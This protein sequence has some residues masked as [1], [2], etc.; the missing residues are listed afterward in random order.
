M[1][2]GFGIGASGAK[3]VL[4]HVVVGGGLLGQT[5]CG[6]FPPNAACAATFSVS[7]APFA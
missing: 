5:R 4:P 7:L 1:L 3:A 2:L 6:T